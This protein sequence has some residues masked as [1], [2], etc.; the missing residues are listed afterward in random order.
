MPAVPEGSEDVV[1]TRAA[2]LMVMLMLELADCDD[3][4][5]ESVTLTVAEEVPIALCAGVPVMVPVEGL[6]ERPVGRLAAL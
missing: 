6:M 5:V 3:G 4:W 2:G 1:T